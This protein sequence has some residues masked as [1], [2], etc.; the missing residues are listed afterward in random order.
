MVC[1]VMA[2]M[3]AAA[4]CILLA[5]LSLL[6]SVEDA[7]YDVPALAVGLLFAMPFIRDV[8]PDVPTV[9]VSVDFLSY[10]W[11]LLIIVIATVLSL[12]TTLYRLNRRS[13][14][15]EMLR[16]VDD[17]LDSFEKGLER[18]P[19]TEGEEKQ[20]HLVPGQK[21]ERRV[22]FEPVNFSSDATPGAPAA[23]TAGDADKHL[24]LTAGVSAP[25]GHEEVKST[26][27]S[28]GEGQ[29]K[30]KLRVENEWPEDGG[31]KERQ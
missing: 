28:P 17:P 25:V 8:M 16:W 4:I 19:E 31:G 20:L 5:A 3:W 27:P 23:A 12:S 22:P 9:G 15:Q 6:R 18:A 30:E 2:L 13:L 10:Y 29:E 24:V 7:S 14:H 11:V 26:G 1:F 21:G